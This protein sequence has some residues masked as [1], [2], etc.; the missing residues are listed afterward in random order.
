MVS[1]AEMLSMR[2]E[3][4]MEALQR[5]IDMATETKHTLE[6]EHEHDQGNTDGR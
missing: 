1:E 6:E 5:I 2:L 4:A 3:V